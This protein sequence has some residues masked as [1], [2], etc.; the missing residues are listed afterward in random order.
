MIISPGRVRCFPPREWQVR[1]LT[2][3]DSHWRGPLAVPWGII[4]KGEPP[5]LGGMIGYPKPP[6]AGYSQGLDSGGTPLLRNKT[7]HCALSSHHWGICCQIIYTA[8]FRVKI[9][10]LLYF[11]QS[12]SSLIS[13][14]SPF[15]M[16]SSCRII[17][18]RGWSYLASSLFVFSLSG[19]QGEFFAEKSSS[20]KES[21]N[22]TVTVFLKLL[23]FVWSVLEASFNLQ[24]ILISIF[25]PTW[26]CALY[27]MI[28]TVTLNMLH[29]PYVAH[30]LFLQIRLNY[31]CVMLT[32]L[33]L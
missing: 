20:K 10:P 8:S 17:C 16:F 5:F 19:E 27:N 15:L 18:S 11:W 1:S 23:T 30:G 32:T 13:F 25:L 31:Q 26:F 2:L 29:M 6:P 14:L 33:F 22:K 7:W 3:L 21:D 9:S 12:F 28:P 4:K 24:T